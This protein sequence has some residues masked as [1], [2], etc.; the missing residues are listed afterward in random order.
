MSMSSI[1]Q[2]PV[3]EQLSSS[4]AQPKYRYMY[5]KLTYLLPAIV[6][7]ASS[8]NSDAT[9]DI[10]PSERAELSF[11]VST[12]SRGSVTTSI[13]QFLVYGDTKPLSPENSTP[14]IVFNKTN[15]EY[16]NDSWWYDGTQYW[17]PNY[18]H[19]FVAVCPGAIF[20]NDNEPRYLN[21]ELAFE[22]SMPVSNGILSSNDDVADILIATHRRLYQNAGSGAAL[23]NQVTLKFRHL[24]SL[25]NLAPAFHDNN[26]NSD[27]Y[28]LIHKLELS[29]VKTKA[30]FNILPAPR[31]S[32]N[33]T[34]DMTVDVAPQDEA[35][36]TIEFSSPV[37]IENNATNVS[38]FAN[39]DA[40]IMMPQEFAADSD[41]EITLFYTITGDDTLRQGSISL[42]NLKWESG[43]SYF[44][45]FTIERIGLRFDSCEINP[46]NVIQGEDIS[47]D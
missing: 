40:L 3:D 44:Y 32:N 39:D 35:D 6:L 22:Y 21:S 15:V 30:Q 2:P 11:N 36:I 41:A 42:T 24:L 1:Y 47:V 8:C 37:K 34:D 25:I 23:N 14:I 38:L 18:E 33:Q 12:L 29:G 16:K 17:I 7:L 20:E 45:K 43:K 27:D 31:L 26:L 10:N 28:I 13:S 46:W 19:S 4:K 5:L 9:D